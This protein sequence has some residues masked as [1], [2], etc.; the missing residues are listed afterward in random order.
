MKSVVSKPI[1][2][3]LASWFTLLVI[4]WMLINVYT[5]MFI[6]IDFLKSINTVSNL[7][8]IAG[9]LISNNPE[10][11]S[12]LAVNQI[13]IN[14]MYLGFTK[15]QE[16]EAEYYAIDTLNKLNLSSNSIIL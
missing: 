7:S 11:M 10:V 13:G 14:N 4:Q 12:S 5:Y 6:T 8:I 2:I 16:R 1:A 15:D 9:S 3:M